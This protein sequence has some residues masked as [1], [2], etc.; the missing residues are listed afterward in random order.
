MSQ[1]NGVTFAMFMQAQFV[2]SNALQYHFR[3]I[4]SDI[5]IKF[6]ILVEES[7]KNSAIKDLSIRDVKA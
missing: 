1:Y 4:I 7:I 6:V 5:K 2:K 3:A